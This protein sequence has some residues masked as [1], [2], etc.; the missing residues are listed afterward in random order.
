MRS[1]FRVLV[2]GCG[3]ALP[4]VERFHSAFL[5]V[6]R[7]WKVLFDCGEGTQFQLVRYRA[8]SFFDVV[9]ITHLHGDHVFGLPG[10][11]FTWWLQG[12]TKPLTLVGPRALG[13]MLM[14]VERLYGFKPEY[15]VD[16]VEVASSE[17]L[18]VFA[19]EAF[20]ILA[21]P[22]RHGD[23]PAYGYIFKEKRPT[24]KINPEAVKRYGVPPQALSEVQRGAHW[25]SPE[26]KLIPNE[27]LT[28][29]AP[30]PRSFAYIT[31]TAYAPE[32]IP[33][34]KNVSLLYHEAT[35]AEEHRHLEAAQGHSTARQAA[36]IAA[37]AGVSHLLIG[38]L[39]S[40]YRRM[41][42]RVV[43]EA[44]EVFPSVV[45]A[46]PGMWITIGDDGRIKVER[47]DVAR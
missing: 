47:A 30:L 27:E 17:P 36:Q 14:C 4:S 46:E 28:V 13:E 18:E 12:R 32:L 40:R 20:S 15:S 5:V 33:V 43:E 29:P 11:L 45:L 10:L 37:Q 6:Y 31:D 39:S 35:F 41:E 34:L 42:Q 25:R 22:L 7:N 26:G 44:R 21:V 8:L 3:S 16:V 38:H 24:R 9:C 19:S 23:M 2:V 1:D